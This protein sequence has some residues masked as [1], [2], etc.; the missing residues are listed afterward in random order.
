M[1]RAFDLCIVVSEGNYNVRRIKFKYFI[2]FSGY[3]GI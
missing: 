3:N 2:S 1:L